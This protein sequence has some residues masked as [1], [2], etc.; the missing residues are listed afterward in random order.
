MSPKICS[1]NPQPECFPKCP[2]QGPDVFSTIIPLNN[3][4]LVPKILK[5]PLKWFSKC[6]YLFPKIG[7]QNSIQIVPEMTSSKTVPSNALSILLSVPICPRSPHLSPQ[8]PHPS[9][10]FCPSLLPLPGLGVP[11]P[12]SRFGVGGVRAQHDQGPGQGRERG[13][14][15]EP[16][17]PSPGPTAK[18]EAAHRHSCFMATGHRAAWLRAPIGQGVEGRG[19]RCPARLS[20]P[21]CPLGGA[22]ARPSPT[23]G[24]PSPWWGGREPGRD[25]GR[26]RGRGAALATPDPG[27]PEEQVAKRPGSPVPPGCPLIPMHPPPGTV[28]TSWSWLGGGAQVTRRALGQ[29]PGSPPCQPAHSPAHRA[30]LT[31]SLP[32]SLTHSLIRPSFIQSRTATGLRGSKNRI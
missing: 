29:R 7:P 21:A 30:L 14:R 17:A 10:H 12:P 24:S 22:K 13:V 25:L 2:P 3:P 4:S 8:M 16:R 18:D 19:R 20:C 11:A 32:H 28:P 9:P 5:G 26:E 27:D 15:T 6:P 23:P 1:P 31:H